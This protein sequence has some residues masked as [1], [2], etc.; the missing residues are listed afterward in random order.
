MARS[1]VIGLLLCIA[2]LLACK[3]DRQKVTTTPSSPAAT[4][5]PTS[6]PDATDTVNFVSKVP[7]P[8]GTRATYR[9]DF[10]MKITQ[11]GQVSRYHEHEE[12]VFDVKATDGFKVTGL[13]IDV[14][15]KVKTEQTGNKAEKRTT[16][17]L[18]GSKYIVTL[19]A[20]GK[21]SATDP[22]GNKTATSQLKLLTE[23]YKGRFE[24]DTTAE[25]LPQR[26]MKLGEKLFPATPTMLRVMSI[27]DDGKTSFEGTEF[28]LES[29]D[30][31]VATFHVE[32]VMT[33]KMLA[34]Q[35]LRAKLSGKMRFLVDGVWTTA[36]ELSGPLTL[37][38]SRG[39]Q[40]AEGTW[41]M[42]ASQ[43]Y[44]R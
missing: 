22:A 33:M 14:R 9:S 7:P 5:A 40:K 19:G 6:P 12:S 8:P 16:S 4:T 32:M 25:F 35:R 3:E 44:D 11:R 10:T 23:D 38:D 20:N 27:K 21:L 41:A 17:P 29:V 43:S 2:A 24:K 26:P 31:G 34:S 1:S 37:L 30:G 13:L 28:L 39:N 42:N 18:A 36:I 15:D